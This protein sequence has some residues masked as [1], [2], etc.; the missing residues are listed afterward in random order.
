MNYRLYGETVEQQIQ[1]INGVEPSVTRSLTELCVL[2]FMVKKCL[3]RGD[4]F[5]TRSRY[6]EW[7]HCF[8]KLV[9]HKFDTRHRDYGFYLV[10]QLIVEA[11]DDGALYE[12]L[13]AMNNHVL[14]PESFKHVHRYAMDFAQ[15]HFPD[16]YMQQQRI[17][18]AVSGHVEGYKPEPLA[19]LLAASAPI[20]LALP[21]RFLGS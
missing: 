10:N 11:D 8:I 4:D 14:T 5:V 19:Y 15:K 21:Q 18:H 17:I 7:I 9:R 16:D 2:G 1:D 13:R 3:E 20:T 6:T 12:D